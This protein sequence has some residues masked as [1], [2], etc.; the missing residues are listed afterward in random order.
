MKEVGIISIICS[1]GLA[2]VGQL[3]QPAPPADQPAQQPVQVAAPEPEQEPEESISDS[4]SSTLQDL[5]STASLQSQIEELQAKIEEL[6]K[7]ACDCNCECNGSCSKPLSSPRSVTI[8]PSEKTFVL[9]GVRYSLPDYLSLYRGSGPQ[10]SINGSVD[11]HITAHGASEFQGLT[12]YEKLELH[13]ALH[14]AGVQAKPIVV[15]PAKTYRT[16]PSYSYSSSYSNCA[17]GNCYR[18]SRRR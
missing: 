12:T 3:Q 16:Y 14:N 2:V 5:V 10:V 11:Q 13:T 6:E 18:R 15:Q 4:F 7:E 17:N 1:I 9:N 8:T